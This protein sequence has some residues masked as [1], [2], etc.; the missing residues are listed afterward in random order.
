M[1]SVIKYNKERDHNVHDEEYLLTK[2][3][4]KSLGYKVAGEVYDMLNL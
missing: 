1:L 2:V 4:F 3:F